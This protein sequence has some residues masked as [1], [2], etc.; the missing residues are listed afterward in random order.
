MSGRGCAPLPLGVGAG[1]GG[2]GQGARQGAGEGHLNRHTCKGICKQRSQEPTT[3]LLAAASRCGEQAAG[4]HCRSFRLQLR[5]H[6]CA[7]FSTCMGIASRA[8]PAVCLL[9]LHATA[10]R[11]QA[12]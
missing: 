11:A 10:A 7:L 5:R 9:H 8:P 12:H 4:G 3:L 1:V 2:G 6:R